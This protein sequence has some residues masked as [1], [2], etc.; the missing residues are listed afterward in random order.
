[1]SDLCTT[2]EARSADFHCCDLHLCR[3]CFNKHTKQVKSHVLVQQAPIEK[4]QSRADNI[5]TETKADELLSMNTQI[6]TLTQTITCY[7]QEIDLLRNR[8]ADLSKQLE[9]KSRELDELRDTSEKQI[10]SYE[11]LIKKLQTPVSPR[12]ES[13]VVSTEKL[14]VKAMPRKT[15][16]LK[17]ADSSTSIIKKK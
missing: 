4:V 16:T 5:E 7:E 6:D 1:M 10:A 15:S 9:D 12:V 2:C 17:K 14:V 8:N 11:A 13:K 3:P